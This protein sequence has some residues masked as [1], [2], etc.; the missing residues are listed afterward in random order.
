VVV[1]RRMFR[2][3]FKTVI[4]FVA[5]LVVIW[6]VSDQAILR[7]YPLKYGDLVQIYS[8]RFNVDPFLVLA[9]IKAESNFQPGAVSPKNA[10]GLMQISEGT[11]KWGAGRLNL[12]DYTSEK[13]FEPE[14]NIYIGCWY[15]SVL[16]DEFGDSDL[17]IAAYN[18]GSGNV[19]QWLNDR[20]LSADGKTLDR[21]PFRETD[22]YLK[23]VN[24]YYSIYKRLYESQ[25]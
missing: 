7:L 11:G 20:D 19:T 1:L 9:I 10:R 5:I 2:I 24:N 6:F 18:G 21:I 8:E 16:Y 3:R 14:I 25:F 15:L 23:K 13:L 22:Q 17:V 4:I 12:E